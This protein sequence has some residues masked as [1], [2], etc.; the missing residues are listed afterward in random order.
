MTASGNLPEIPGKGQGTAA[1]TLVP[2]TTS[3]FSVAEAG[4]K[5]MAREQFPVEKQQELEAYARNLMASPGFTVQ[6]FIGMV[7]DFDIDN[8]PGLDAMLENVKV[9]DAGELGKRVQDTTKRMR[10]VNDEMPDIDLKVAEKIR[11]GRLAGRRLLRYVQSFAR[12]IQA[13]IQEYESM[14][15]HIERNVQELEKRYKLMMEAVER[16]DQLAVEADE[17][18][19]KLLTLCAVLE[20]LQDMMGARL[21]ELK[22]LLASGPNAELQDEQTRLIGISPLMIKRLGGMKPMIHVSHMNV[23][24]FIGQR[25]SF[26]IL[27]IDL[28]DMIEIA[29]P[30]WKTDIVIE[31]GALQAQA[32]SFV[33]TEA[34]EIFNDQADRASEAYKAQIEVVAQQMGEWMIKAETFR[35]MQLAIIEA[36][37]A[38]VEGIRAAAKSGDEVAREVRE[39]RDTVKA[40]QDKLRDELA[41]ILE[42]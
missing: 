39:G 1:L 24:R 23:D 17:R 30:Q 19:E 18:T 36:G 33:L 40:H 26:A 34:K 13:A 35:N 32:A 38:W 10:Q 15:K 31:L 16:S 4:P 8:V 28:G 20:Y 42:S 6:F 7:R 22:G 11:Q 25:N 27:A 5:F 21:T 41:S 12:E 14:L 3:Q 37:E 9:H 2:E 29:I